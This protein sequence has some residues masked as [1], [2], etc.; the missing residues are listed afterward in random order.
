MVKGEG[1]WV[2][3]YD[4]DACEV[5]GEPP[6]VSRKSVADPDN[7]QYRGTLLIGNPAGF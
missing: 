6:I 7:D 2:Q 1:C 4:D 3:R 5:C